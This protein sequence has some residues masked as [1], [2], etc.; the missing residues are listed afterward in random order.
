M[1]CSRY[2]SGHAKQHF[3][4][5]QHTLAF[6]I[7]TKL[8]YWYRICALTPP[9]AILM[10]SISSY[11]CDSYVPNDNKR[12]DLSTIRQRLEEIVTCTV[13]ESKTRRGTILHASQHV[14]SEQALLKRTKKCVSLCAVCMW[15]HSRDLPPSHQLEDKVFS[16][17]QHWRLQA[18]SR[19]FNKWRQVCLRGLLTQ[20]IEEE[21]KS[22]KG[23]DGKKDA[24]DEKIK[25]TSS[26]T[27]RRGQRNNTEVRLNPFIS[28]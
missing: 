15:S 5:S 17:V 21:E 22:Q 28:S 7:N 1:G 20:L 11:T 26:T 8:C 27:E 3:E 24:A 25:E 9:D 13:P 2:I 16:A 19:A 23:K 12:E 6:E 4:S 14:P 18:L 10:P